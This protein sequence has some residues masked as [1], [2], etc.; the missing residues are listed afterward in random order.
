MCNKTVAYALFNTVYQLLN[1][2]VLSL[3]LSV[4]VILPETNTLACSFIRSPL[5][6]FLF[7]CCLQHGNWPGATLFCVAW[8]FMN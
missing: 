7:Y 1:K 4:V 5:E 3:M 2:V 8:N 6:P